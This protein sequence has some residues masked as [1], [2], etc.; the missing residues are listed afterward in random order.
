MS[1]PVSGAEELSLSE[2]SD[3]PEVS[4]LITST[5][6][7]L[8]QAAGKAK[9]SPAAADDGLSYDGGNPSS[10]GDEEEEPVQDER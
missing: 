10:E 3:L 4:Q 9:S 5:Q 7:D 2:D 8:V 6:A 1:G